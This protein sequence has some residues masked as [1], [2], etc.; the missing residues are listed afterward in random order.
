MKHYDLSNE[1][2]ENSLRAE[3]ILHLG[4]MC[5][6]YSF[7][8]AAEEAFEEDGELIL[9]ALGIPV[10]EDDDKFNTLFS[11][12]WEDMAALLLR[13]RKLGYLAQ[14]ATPMPYDFV[15]DGYSTGGWG[16]TVSHWFYGETFQDCFRQAVAWKN[17][18]IENRRIAAKLE[19]EAAQ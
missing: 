8:S 1:C 9:E 11:R 17:R 12:P 4:C 19:T 2:F 3:V 7:P 10:P 16:A 18:F 6:D 15:E 5:F 13:H 14:F